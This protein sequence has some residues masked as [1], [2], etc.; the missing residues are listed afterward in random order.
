MYANKLVTTRRAIENSNSSH[1]QVMEPVASNNP[2]YPH[3]DILFLV[4]VVE[5]IHGSSEPMFI[6]FLGDGWCRARSLERAL[7]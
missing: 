6:I 4:F 2:P 3:Y 1:S 7:A 5:G